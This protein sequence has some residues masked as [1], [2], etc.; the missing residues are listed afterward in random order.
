MTTSPGSC[1]EDDDCDE[2]KTCV[3]GEC[4]IEPWYVDDLEAEGH[5]RLKSGRRA[6][7]A[8]PPIVAAGVIMLPIGIVVDRSG[9]DTYAE[10]DCWSS[11]SD[12]DVCNEA[13]RRAERGTATWAVGTAF[14]IAGVGTTVLGAILY[15][16]GKSKLRR[17]AQYRKQL[18]L[19]LT[20]GP[21]GVRGRF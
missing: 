4:R 2:P 18:S 17:S 16:L 6:L 5:A 20:P 3:R 9:W 21:F 7:I 12:R 19:D 13:L 14:L 10:N 1:S 8:G 15:G 11:A